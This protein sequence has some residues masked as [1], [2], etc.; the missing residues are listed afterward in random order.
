M[1]FI[2]TPE[3]ARTRRSLNHEQLA[4]DFAGNDPLALSLQ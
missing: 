2:I 1:R 3:S 4:N